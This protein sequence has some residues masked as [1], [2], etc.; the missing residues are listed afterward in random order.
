MNDP[1]RPIRQTAMEAVKK[2]K[3]S[4]RMISRL[5]MENAHLRAQLATRDAEL[6][7]TWN[8]IDKLQARERAFV[9]EL[10]NEMTL[11]AELTEQIEQ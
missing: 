8:R 10:I 7:R 11:T 9:R 3:I 5:N 2:L 6:S 1:I 4:L